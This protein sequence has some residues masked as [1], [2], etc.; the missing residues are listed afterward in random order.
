MGIQN[1]RSVLITERNPMPERTAAIRMVQV[2][3]DRE[4]TSLIII[5][6]W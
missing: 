4:G 6:M 3:N 2:L 5:Y 1:G